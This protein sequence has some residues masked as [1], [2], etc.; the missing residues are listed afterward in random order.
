[1]TGFYV[2]VLCLLLASVS[3][4]SSGVTSTDEAKKMALGKINSLEK[5]DGYFSNIGIDVDLFPAPTVSRQNKIF[6]VDF[7]DSNQNIWVVVSI[8]STGVIE[9]SHTEL[10]KK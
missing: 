3:G 6:L 7:K 10:I 8:G 5:S 9:V 1:M 4:C 2:V